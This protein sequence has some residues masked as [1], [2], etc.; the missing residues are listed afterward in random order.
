MVAQLGLDW[1]QIAMLVT[2]GVVAVLLALLVVYLFKCCKKQSI[3]RLAFLVWGACFGSFPQ[4]SP[5]LWR[6]ARRIQTLI[7]SAIS[8]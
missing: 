5:P 7:V 4:R 2:L 8:I 1:M 3:E 6:F